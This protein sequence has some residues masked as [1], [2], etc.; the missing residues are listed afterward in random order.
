MTKRFSKAHYEEAF[1][2]DG[3]LRDIY[4]LSTSLDDWDEFLKYVKSSS[5]PHSFG[6][7]H[8][9]APMPQD[10]R[11]ALSLRHDAAPL[12]QIDLRGATLNCHFFHD[13][14]I[15]LDLDPREI[16][17]DTRA[18]AV[19]AFMAEMSAALRKE[20]RLT[21]ENSPERIIFQCEPKTGSVRYVAP[22]YGR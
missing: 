9:L 5:Y 18:D 13:A 21:E 4:V 6:V 14:D 22:D 1:E 15:E 7:N 3:F 17:D 10:A 11:I 19:L 12:L 16:V 2:V 8:T 20:V